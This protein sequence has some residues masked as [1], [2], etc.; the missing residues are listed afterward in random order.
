MS[1]TGGAGDDVCIGPGVGVHVGMGLLLNRGAR[2]PVGFDQFR[3]LNEDEIG[4]QDFD[5]L[6]DDESGHEPYFVREE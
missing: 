4:H 6:K 3:V 5:V 1:D 2:V